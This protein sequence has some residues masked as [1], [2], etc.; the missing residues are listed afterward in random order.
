M[1]VIIII[2]IIIIVIIALPNKWFKSKQK[3]GQQ[4]FKS[5]DGTGVIIVTFP[6]DHSLLLLLELVAMAGACH[7]P[8]WEPQLHINFICL[9]ASVQEQQQQQ[10]RHG[11]PYRN[12]KSSSNKAAF[13]F[14]F[15]IIIIFSLI[16]YFSSLIISSNLH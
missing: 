8:E 3:F 1:S 2:I 6:Y 13:S 14:I 4:K 10:S 15:I 9:T 5:I 11:S 12:P 7:K 16:C